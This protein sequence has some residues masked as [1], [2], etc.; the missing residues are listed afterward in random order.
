MNREHG[1]STCF[2]LSPCFS[3]AMSR[4]AKGGLFVKRGAAPGMVLLVR[5]VCV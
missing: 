1:E 3:N 2:V 5:G 4:V